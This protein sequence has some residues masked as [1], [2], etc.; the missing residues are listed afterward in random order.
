MGLRWWRLWVTG[1]RVYVTNRQTLDKLADWEKTVW[2]Y[3]PVQC[4]QYV[5]NVYIYW[6]MS[7]RLRPLWTVRMT[8]VCLEHR[9]CS[10]ISNDLWPWYDPG[11]WVQ[12][13][14][15]LVSIAD[16]LETWENLF[17]E[18]SLKKHIVCMKYKWNTHDL[19]NSLPQRG[20]QWILETFLLVTGWHVLRD[21]AK[22]QAPALLFLYVNER[23][24]IVKKHVT[25]SYCHWMPLSSHFSSHSSL[26]APCAPGLKEDKW[27]L[28]CHYNVCSSLQVM[29]SITEVVKSSWQEDQS[30]TRPV[31]CVAATLDTSY[32]VIIFDD[33]LLMC[34]V[35]NVSLLCCRE[36]LTY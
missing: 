29:F 12:E 30:A 33:S 10:R 18:Q 26:Q 9:T 7:V 14:R 1:E 35:L 23:W 17:K 13:V 20:D 8:L 22:C 32:S 31:W 15:P 6:P 34:F 28:L 4:V 25:P 24:C 2:G 21:M 3:W 19:N 5:C 27:C 11:A 16:N 36:W